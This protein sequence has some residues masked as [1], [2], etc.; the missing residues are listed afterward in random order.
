MYCTACGASIP[1]KARFCTACGAALSAS[2]VTPGLKTPHPR[3][4][5]RIWPWFVLAATVMVAIVVVVVVTIPGKG[6]EPVL[7]W[8]SFYAAAKNISARERSH[9]TGGTEHFIPLVETSSYSYYS[10]TNEE[11]MILFLLN[12][13]ILRMQKPFLTT[14]LTMLFGQASYT[15]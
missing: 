3:A 14:N 9:G 4:H 12:W 13:K 2:G 1:S 15:T 5:R 6:K 7:S 8:E 11:D 10:S